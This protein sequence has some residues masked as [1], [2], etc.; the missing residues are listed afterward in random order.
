[1]GRYQRGWLRVVER[2][3]GCRAWQFRYYVIDSVSGK[4]QERSKIIGTLA[5]F[6]TETKCWHEID[7]QRLVEKINQ[8]QTDDKL[9]FRQIAEFYLNSDAFNKLASTTQYCYRHI[10][11]D[12]L[13][14][15]WGDQ[16]AV[17]IK[18]LAVEKWLRSLKLAAPTRGKTKYVMM[19]VFLHAEKHERI[20]ERVH[21]QSGKQDRHRNLFGLRGRNPDAQADVHNSKANGATGKH[22][23][24]CWLRLRALRFSEVAGL[25]WQDVDYANECIHVRRK[26]I[27]GR[28][29]EELKTKKSRSAVPMAAV[30]A[31][32]LREWQNA[33]AYG[34]ST[35]WVFASAKTHGRTPRVG[36]MLVADHLRPA[37]IKAGVVLKPG[38]RFGFHNLR[39][40]LSS[41]LIT[42]QK[43][44]VRTTQDILRHSSS[45]TTID[46]YTQSPMAQRIAAQE[47]VLRA[48]LKA[49][50][51]KGENQ[52]RRGGSTEWPKNRVAKTR[53]S[54][55]KWNVG[56][57]SRLDRRI[58][59][60]FRRARSRI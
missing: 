59:F 53:L 6:P 29:S 39:H 38:Q 47:S 10:V 30:L 44:D 28:A 41:L 34:K 55:T 8:P 17:D 11:N 25:Q 13:V 20:P 24:A 32:F 58:A 45:A 5:D 54:P 26:W 12:Y 27:G 42:G 14:P 50:D 23:D 56:R 1:M 16:F 31:Q 7:R 52:E 43:S 57:T 33:T 46:L 35:D 51:Q 9:R 40:S 4:K 48:I 49:P 2:K 19:V 3:Q 22:H 15:A 21:G 37:A 36:N 60:R 18:S